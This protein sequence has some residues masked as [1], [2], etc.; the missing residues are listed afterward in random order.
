M[1]EFLEQFLIESRETVEQAV[2]DLMALEKAPSE[3]AVHLDGAFRAFHTLKGSAGIVGFTAMEEAVHAAEDVLA[4]MRS[5]AEAVTAGTIGDCVACLDQVSRWLDALERTGEIPQD[6]TA[7]AAAVLARF[8]DAGRA[9][10]SAPERWAEDLL[11]RHPAVRAEAR[12]AVRY[13]PQPEC[14]YQGVDPLALIAALPGLLV[15]EVA[16]A[17]PWPA[18][19]ELDPFAC[20]VVVTAL[21]RS[22]SAEVIQAMGAEAGHCRWQ[23]LASDAASARLSPQ[24]REVLE[25][26][27][28]LLQEAGTPRSI[29]RLA[30]IGVVAANVLCSA[31]R[32]ADAERMLRA[33]QND[34]D[35]GALPRL[36]EAIAALLGEGD[37]LVPA[38]AASARP[39]EVAA[40][41]LRIDAARIDA[42]VNLTGELIVAKNAI[43]HLAKMAQESGE[44]LAVGLKR[45]HA[46]LE[47]LVGELQQ[48][49][50]G[51]RVLPLHHVFQRF[52]RLVREMASELGKQ[53]E[54]VMEGGAT[55]ADK[56][57][58]EMLFEPLLHVLRNALDH[59]V[60]TA[61]DRAAQRKSAVATIHLRARSEAGQ[62]V[63]EVSDDGRGV[64]VD[65]VRRV[66]QTR[67]LAAAEEIAALSDTEAID[68]IFAP[69]FST[70]TE[71]TGLSG[72][73]V[74][75][76]AVRA[77]VTRLGGHVRI[78]SRPRLGTT[79][80]FTL[81]FSVMMTRVMVVRSGGQ[82]FGV[83]LDRVV[84]TV[85]IGADK[86]LPVGAS[87]AI[88]VRDR[89]VPLVT[90]ATALGLSV[91]DPAQTE[92]TVVIT[93]IHGQYCALRVD[94][95]GERMDVMLKPLD[96]LLAGSW[97]LAGSTVLGDGSVLLILDLEEI[98]R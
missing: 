47:H 65:A 31:G 16:A 64:D 20:N 38:P 93:L 69:G 68:L 9:V 71:V 98:F 7:Q 48:A 28:Q 32:V 23:A 61:A 29:G 19:S 56:T 78:D 41:V 42:L 92:A 34:V 81:P 3:Q 45:Q 25:A 12:S 73:G 84:E 52:P 66:A 95:I 60:E 13:T 58:V 75:L 6:A 10:T 37:P 83:P 24:A 55:E 46:V 87:A 11:D 97:G 39:P 2:A 44:A 63:V 88:L 33:V 26:Q 36:Q 50:I 86:I 70:A 90:L 77:A 94:R 80:R 40:R 89:T 62:V 54:L 18:L 49:V 27:L 17:K 91:D 67:A 21:T 82:S 1:N 14:F 59:G 15:I 76:D 79:I 4:C 8:A 72:R 85:R 35:E 5:G 53:A 51:V 22:S 74:G 43:G 57:I 30:S 96:G